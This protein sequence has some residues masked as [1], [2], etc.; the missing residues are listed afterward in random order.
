MAERRLA[1]LKYSGKTP[2][3]AMCERCRLKFFT[4][5]ELTK[6]PVEA[7]AN[8]RAKFEVHECKLVTFPPFPR[9]I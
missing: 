2:W 1:I 3:F 8:L 5:K 4:P 9:P 7:E 6:H